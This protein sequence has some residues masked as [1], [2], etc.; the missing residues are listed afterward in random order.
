MVA[1]PAPVPAA[2]DQPVFHQCEPGPWGRIEYQYIYIA[3]PNWILEQY[4]MPQPQ[5]RWC[6]PDSTAASVRAFLTQSGLDATTCDSLL[7]DPRAL[8][9]EEGIFTVFPTV[10]ELIAISPTVRQTIYHELA[11]S[12]LN[13]FQYEPICIPDGDLDGWLSSSGLPDDVASDIRKLVWRDGDSLLFS[14]FRAILSHATSDSEARRWVKALTRVRA[15]VAYLKLAEYHRK[16]SLPMLE[17]FAN[18]PGENRLDLIHL[19]PPFPRRLVYSY[20]T[21]DIERTGQT[22]NCHWTSLNFF[23]Y[24]RQNIYLDLKLASSQVMED[25]EKVTG[26]P[27]FGDVL[28]FLNTNED[29]FHSCVYIADDLVFTKNGENIMMP[30]LLTRLTD[31]KQLYMREPGTHIEVY[32]RRWPEENM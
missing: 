14:D 23:N 16:D 19:L 10:D 8:R 21:P 15:V 24:T 13:T 9:D 3:A 12:S 31:V 2:G 22:P 20:T 1:T 7:S 4:P 29:A 5:P 11:K 27:Q 17:A 6:F 25:Y 32:R 30:W 28:F 18:L 26:S